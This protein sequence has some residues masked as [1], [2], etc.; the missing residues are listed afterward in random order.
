[1]T[2]TNKS[3]LDEKIEEANKLVND[4][5][6]RI[7]AVETKLADKKAELERANQKIK[8]AY[9]VLDLQK[10]AKEREQ[11]NSLRIEIEMLTENK[12]NCKPSISTEKARQLTEDLSEYFEGY[13][14]EVL[15]ELNASYE[16]LWNKMEALKAVA[17]TALDAISN[18]EGYVSNGANISKNTGKSLADFVRGNDPVSSF[19][20]RVSG[21]YG[22]RSPFS[23][24]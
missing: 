21:S 2:R 19:M 9:S 15:L 1:M 3:V 22:S 8:E 20:A 7:E 17:N 5:A 24:K 14:N 12:K 13:E 6:S 16:T 23:K 11:A 4:V 18:M 10:Y